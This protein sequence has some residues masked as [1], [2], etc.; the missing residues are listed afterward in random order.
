MDN[1]GIKGYI[2]KYLEG[3]ISEEEEKQLERFEKHLVQRN[4]HKV[5]RNDHHKRMVKKQ[6]QTVIDNPF[7]KKRRQYLKIAAS[8]VIMLG[9][10]IT[11]YYS[12]RKPQVEI[13][14]IIT[15]TTELGQKMNITLSDGTKVRLNSG[16]ALTF[17]QKFGSDD[18]TR[19]VELVG[20]AFFE[21]TK[22]AKRPF[23]ITSGGL[24]TTV[25][26]TSFN[27]NAYPNNENI[28][29]TVATGKVMVTSNDDEFALTPNQQAVYHKEQNGIIKQEVDILSFVEWKNG[30][31]RMENITLK[32]AAK[33]LEKWYGVKITFE[34]PRLSKYKFAGTFYNNEKLQVVL[35]SIRYALKEIDY[36]RLGEKEILIKEK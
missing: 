16:S 29:V 28:T 5:F 6:L 11:A 34:N 1:K 12:V 7:K 14:S 8:I 21:V 3:T 31:L 30:T 32:E 36:E 33:E 24:K 19:E 15:S 10:S 22:D 27:I 18:Q 2:K 17:P 4:A 25:L 23:I 13:T 26:G 9:L 35:E 20:E